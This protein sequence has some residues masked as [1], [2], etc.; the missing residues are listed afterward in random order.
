MVQVPRPKV[1]E[2]V[3]QSVSLMPELVLKNVTAQDA[4]DL[5][6]YLV[7]LQAA[8][9]HANSFKCSALSQQQTRTSR[10]DF[11]PNQPRLFRPERQIRNAGGQREMAWRTVATKI[12][13]TA[14][15]IDSRNFRWPQD[16]VIVY[17]AATLDSAGEQPATL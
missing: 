5:L 15:E 1:V 2:L 11:G 3:K 13:S 14:P 16:N 9:I 8:V 7:S 10:T 4:A 12:G 6:A 17:F